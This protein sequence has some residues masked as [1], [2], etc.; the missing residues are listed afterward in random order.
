[1]QQ[2]DQRSVEAQKYKSSYLPQSLRTT[3]GGESAHAI[4][5]EKEIKPKKVVLFLLLLFSSSLV[6][7]DAR[8][9]SI[10][11]IVH[12]WPCASLMLVARPLRFSR[13]TLLSRRLVQ[14]RK[15]APSFELG[16]ETSNRHSSK[17]MRT[18]A[19]SSLRN[20]RRKREEAEKERGEA[21]CTAKKERQQ[22]QQ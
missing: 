5:A 19:P 6:E 16:D 12:L 21:S 4:Q 14:N 13:R 10:V 15:S 17:K 7:V 1:M 2:K 20:R 22:Q 3:N 8:C 18:P 11:A 9:S